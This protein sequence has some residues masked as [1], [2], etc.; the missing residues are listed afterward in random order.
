MGDLPIEMQSL[1]ALLFETQLR[2]AASPEA[3]T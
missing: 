3:K 1:V 2:D